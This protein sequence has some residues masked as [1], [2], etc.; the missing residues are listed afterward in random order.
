MG[1]DTLDE[2]NPDYVIYLQ[3]EGDTLKAEYGCKGE[4]PVPVDILLDM[5]YITYINLQNEDSKTVVP[6]HLH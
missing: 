5:L 3:L 4:G 2:E 1:R 6:T